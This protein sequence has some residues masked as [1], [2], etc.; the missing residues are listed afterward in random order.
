MR[1][2]S[3]ISAGARIRPK[4]ERA[5]TVV[6]QSDDRVRMCVVAIVPLTSMVSFQFVGQ[7]FL[8][9]LVS[10]LVLLAL[11]L[12][13]GAVRQ[14]APLKTCFLLM[15]LWFG[16]ALISDWYRASDP[17][18]FTRGWSRLILLGVNIAMI[19]LLCKGSLKL[20]SLYAISVGAAS[21]LGSLITSDPLAQGDPWKFG[22]GAGLVTIAAALAGMPRFRQGA[23]R[24][25]PEIAIGA[26]S[27]ISLLLNS[28]TIF[29]IGMLTVAYSIFSRWILNHKK[30][31][32]IL[33]FSSVLLAG[34]LFAQIVV[35]SY[36]YSASEGFLGEEAR[37]KFL[38][39]TNNDAGLLLSGRSESLVSF[40]A[41]KDS[42]FIG[43]GSW[44]HDPYYTLIYY[45]K[46]KQ[47]GLSVPPTYQQFGRDFDYLIQTHSH[48]LGAWVEAGILA[49]P[50]WLWVL[51]IAFNTLYAVVARRNQPNTMLIFL[52]LMAI[53]DV[54]FSPFSAQARFTKALQ[55]AVMLFA[56]RAM[57][58]QPLLPAPRDRDEYI[59][60]MRTGKGVSKR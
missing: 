21:A 32:S 4:S 49:V 40:E 14:L 17:A 12:R 28:R 39:Q 37:S 9:D 11:L 27:M 7:L 41:I 35:M 30:S 51:Y 53:W 43:H 50:F 42:P 19:W 3:S 20:L 60:G 36:E 6:K 22:G 31:V 55:I 2:M 29:A 15:A 13:P 38:M 59:R 45:V 25:I 47:L 26:L 16:G 23:I 58:R 52:A 5:P 8:Q 33:G 44:A 46:Q 57:E 54:L 48:I 10:P 56:K 18:D 1:A 34:V 24:Y